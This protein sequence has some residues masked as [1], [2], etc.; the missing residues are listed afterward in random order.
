MAGPVTLDP[1]P[2]PGEGEKPLPRIT[3]IHPPA[4]AKMPP[5]RH[6]PAVPQPRLR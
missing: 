4:L 6:V 3:Q 1:P 2:P 5:I